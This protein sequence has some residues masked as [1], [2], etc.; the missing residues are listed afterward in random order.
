LSTRRGAEKFDSRD[1]FT[2]K[3]GLDRPLNRC[4]GWNVR[5]LHIGINVSVARFAVNQTTTRYT[6]VGFWKTLLASAS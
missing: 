4:A 1:G 3:C 2:A 5:S 6:S